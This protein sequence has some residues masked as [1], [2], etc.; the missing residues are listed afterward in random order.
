MKCAASLVSALSL[1]FIGLAVRAHASEL[2][3]GTLASDLVPGP[4]EYSVVLPDGYDAAA[5]PYPLLLV[6][7]GGGSSHK[8]LATWK[9]SLDALWAS[10]ELAKLVA[11]MPSTGKPT[12]EG[13]VRFMDFRDGSEKWESFVVGP[14]LDHIRRQYKVTTDRAETLVAGFSD[15]GFGT[16]RIGLK[17]PNRFAGLAAFEPA[18]MPALNWKDVEARNLFFIAD[19]LIARFYGNPVDE[20]YWAANNPASIATANAEKIRQS[21]LA[22]YLECGDQDYLNLHEGTEF[23]HQVLWNH[24]ILH[25]YHLVRGADHLGRTLKPRTIE[26]LKFLNRVLNPPGP[27]SDQE[28]GQ[29]KEYFRELKQRAA[30]SPPHRF[31]ARH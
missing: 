30:T 3:E 31:R 5:E 8:E 12:I 23:F 6:L 18:I 1:V 20:A 29:M 15:G 19:D 9:E 24:D 28:L 22:I 11:V 4:V 10:G 27:D 2:R 13:R 21:G 14:F 7:H 17:Y 25:E 26:G 16:L